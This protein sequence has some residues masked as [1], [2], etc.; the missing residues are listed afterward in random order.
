[1]L[2]FRA[3][4]AGGHDTPPHLRAAYRRMRYGTGVT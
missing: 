2:D 1:M 4:V 3:K